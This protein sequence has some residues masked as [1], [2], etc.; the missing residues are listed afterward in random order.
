VGENEILRAQIAELE[1]SVNT[2][3]RND[4]DG[5]MKDRMLY[6]KTFTEMGA[7]NSRLTE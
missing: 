7:E 2:L 6:E 3:S 1:N 5:K 4:D